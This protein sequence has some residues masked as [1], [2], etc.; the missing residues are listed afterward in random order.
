[1]LKSIFIIFIILSLNV[2]GQKIEIEDFINQIAKIEIPKSYE[3]YYLVPES[4]DQPKIY[5]SI[6]NYHIKEFRTN[7]KNLITNLY[8]QNNEEKV[9]WKDYDLEKAKF[10]INEFNYKRTSPPTVKI[11]Q[12][13]KYNI[14]EEKFES[15]FGN[16]KP[17]TVIVKKKWYWNKKRMWENPKFRQELKSAYEKDEKECLEEKVYFQF[18]KP[19]FSSKGKYARVS[20]FRAG[21][22]KG[23]GFTAIYK[24]D[25]NIWKK[26]RE[27]N[28]NTSI[29]TISH[30]SCGD[31]LIT[32]RE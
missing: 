31:V 23:R 4:L 20:I 17:H 3:Y 2:Y 6:K 30:A 28:M 19:I 15:I 22:C 14:S 7:D 32:Y 25:N 11:A 1:M 21:R 18:S 13:V 27:Y 29:V 24:K 5:D 12:F 10:V 26:L 16:K 8:Y 9:N